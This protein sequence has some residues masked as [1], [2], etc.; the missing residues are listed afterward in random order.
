MFFISSYQLVDIILLYS[1][2][3]QRTVINAKTIQ[4]EISI[5]I[6]QCYFPII[7]E[8]VINQISILPVFL[9]INIDGNQIKVRITISVRHYYNS[10]TNTHSIIDRNILHAT[11]MHGLRKEGY[12]LT[13]HFQTDTAPV[14][15]VLRNADNVLT[16]IWSI[17]NL[18]IYLN[19]LTFASSLR[20][21]RLVIYHSLAT[22]ED[23]QN[24]YSVI[25]S[26]PT[27]ISPVQIAPCDRYQKLVYLINHT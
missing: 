11:V 27:V 1:F 8:V 18:K 6:T 15:F 19:S 2:W 3:G 5:I 21:K 4:I 12:I 20:Y 26:Y 23:F 22:G 25:V 24:P 9:P 10:Q 13:G 16:G 7:L 14:C 17:L